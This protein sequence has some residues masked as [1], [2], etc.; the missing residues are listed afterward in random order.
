MNE[1]ILFVAD[2]KVKETDNRR[3]VGTNVARRNATLV[4]D[5]T[6][7]ATKPGAKE[8]NSHVIGNSK[9]RK[10]RMWTAFNSY[11]FYLTSYK[12]A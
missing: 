7:R 9:Y 5:S 2:T 12:D 1:G 3:R 11:S 4:T 10:R 8:K 6:K